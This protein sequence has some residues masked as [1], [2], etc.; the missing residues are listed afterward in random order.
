MWKTGFMSENIAFV[1]REGGGRANYQMFCALQA[2][3]SDADE[4]RCAQRERL[5]AVID[6]KRFASFRSAKN[7]PR[8]TGG[9][10]LS[11]GPRR[12]ISKEALEPSVAA[13]SDAA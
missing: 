3:F 9:C 13:A 6:A 11:H 5:R 7:N 1:R 10:R 12:S 2:L 8:R 4:R